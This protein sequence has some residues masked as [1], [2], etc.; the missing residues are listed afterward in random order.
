[1]DA[2]SRAPP[3]RP[4]PTP[5]Q[6]DIV[7]YAFGTRAVR[8]GAY[9]QE[10]NQDGRHSPSM[11][12]LVARGH[13]ELELCTEYPGVDATDPA[14][15]VDTVRTDFTSARSTHETTSS[16]VGGNATPALDASDAASVATG[17]GPSSVAHRPTR[18]APVPP[19][20]SPPPVPPP[21]TPSIPANGS[22][23]AGAP[24]VP[25]TSALGDDGNGSVTLGMPKSETAAVTINAQ[26]D[27][28]FASA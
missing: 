19:G 20:R 24:A 13:V 2:P 21:P 28:D 23:G 6:R 15:T 7:E 17:V 8:A 14:A 16:L 26:V 9:L 5:L 12:L 11:S 22:R 10:I 4:H 3:S 25:L 1:M 27:L 18:T